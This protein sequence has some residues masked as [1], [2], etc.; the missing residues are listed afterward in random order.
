MNGTN[1]TSARF[2][3][4]LLSLLGV[5]VSITAH[6]A[7]TSAW[8]EIKNSDDLQVFAT[9]VSGSPLLKIRALAVIDAD[10]TDII[11]AINNYAQQPS[12]VPYLTETRVLEERSVTEK[13]LYSRFDAP[14]PVDGR[15]VV[16]HVS[17]QESPDDS[18]TFRQ[19][20]VESPLMPEK[21]GYIRATLMESTYT[22]TPL[23][24][25]RTRAE[26]L[27]HADP[28]GQLPLW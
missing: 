11:T 3:H 26:L 6:A 19:Y 13:L 17:R 16:Y 24:K 18:I 10:V 20:S 15:D 14:W 2:V 8:Q 23:A 1:L 22:L 28:H 7:T 9:Q 5:F 27:F 4:R 12:W 21:E 25:G